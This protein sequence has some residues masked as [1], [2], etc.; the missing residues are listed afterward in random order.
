[1]N[2]KILV[3]GATGGIG[4]A[5]CAKLA[6]ENYCV[7]AWS[8]K[9]LDLNY[10]EKI[11]EKD[12]SYYNTII[13]CAGHSV[14]TYQG[15]LKNSWQN[16]ESQINVNYVSNLF[17]CKHFANSVKEGNYIWCHSTSIDNPRPF[18]SVYAGTK[19]ASEF[20]LELIAQE[21][22]HITI[23]GVKFGLVRTNFRYRNFDGSKTVE[24]VEQTYDSETCFT[25]VEEVANVIIQAIK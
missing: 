4:S 24:E 21:A 14:G 11:F 25:D 7:T 3:I 12:F 19:A 22:D 2:K 5:V 1:M 16:Q 20:S 15:F 18:Q 8:S 10:P 6:E 23:T 17:L 9:D 13:N